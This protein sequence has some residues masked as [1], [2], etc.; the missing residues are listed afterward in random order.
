MNQPDWK[1][2]VHTMLGAGYGVEDIAIKATELKMKTTP[3]TVR[4][5]VS[6]LR[7]SGRLK[8]VLFPRWRKK[9]GIRKDE[10]GGDREPQE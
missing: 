8:A 3:D 1:T 9:N 2:V 6:R 7:E 10:R 5:E 4:D